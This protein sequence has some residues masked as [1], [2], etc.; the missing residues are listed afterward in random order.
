MAS[1]QFQLHA[2]ICEIPFCVSKGRKYPPYNYRNLENKPSQNESSLQPPC[3]RGYDNIR[4]SVIYHDK[5]IF[6]MGQHISFAT[7]HPRSMSTVA[8]FEA[9]AF[10][11]SSLHDVV[12]RGS[13]KTFIYHCHPGKGVDTTDMGL[14]TRGLFLKHTQRP[15]R[16][17][18]LLVLHGCGIACIEALHSAKW[19][20]L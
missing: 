10:S 13:L 20:I 15:H 9:L 6:N 8:Y 19:S 7:I 16:F 4:E 11:K 5:R 3:F 2:S 17:F 14:C 1:L 18:F 12:N